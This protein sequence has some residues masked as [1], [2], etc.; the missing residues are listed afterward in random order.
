VG[1]PRTVTDEIFVETVRIQGQIE[2][3]RSKLAS[4]Q[5]TWEEMIDS[6]G[7]SPASVWSNWPLCP[8][9]PSHLS[10]SQIN[11][12]LEQIQDQLLTKHPLKMQETRLNIEYEQLF[13]NSQL[14]PEYKEEQAAAEKKWYDDNQSLNEQA[15]IKVKAELASLPPNSMTCLLKRRPVLKFLQFMPS[16]ILLFHVNDF[17]GLSTS[18]SNL[19]LDQTRA[20]LACMPFFKSHQ[21]AQLDFVSILRQR[22]D[23]ETRK[24][25]TPTPEKKRSTA[26]KKKFT[27]NCG[28]YFVTLGPLLRVGLLNLQWPVIK[29][30]WLL[31]P[32][33]NSDLEIPTDILWMLKIITVDLLVDVTLSRLELETQD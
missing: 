18:I 15:L 5:R 26:F 14:F 28:S 13:R 20:V 30:I 16:Q 10:Y 21:E 4:I 2:S 3:L 27:P 25:A 9:P 1:L 29:K 22:V 8:V 11:E 31:Q 23:A 33:E 32:D 19:P 24:L 7:A 6:C 12:R 17:K